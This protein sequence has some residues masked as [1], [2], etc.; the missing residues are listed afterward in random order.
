MIITLGDSPNQS[1]K[2]A[3]SFSWGKRGDNKLNTLDYLNVS[4]LLPLKND[5]VE[6]V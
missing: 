6:L 2:I 5:K 4:F 1:K 3:W